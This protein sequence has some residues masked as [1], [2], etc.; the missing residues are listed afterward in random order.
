MW[1][2][3]LKKRKNASIQYVI[4]I[5]NSDYPVSLDR[6][7][8]Y[9]IMPDERAAEDNCLR[10]I[11]EIWGLSLCFRALC[12]RRFAR[13]IAGVHGP[14]RSRGCRYLGNAKAEGSVE[15]QGSARNESAE[16]PATSKRLIVI[17]HDRFIRIPPTFHLH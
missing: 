6:H 11:D 3:G 16:S 1:N 2:D 9:E 13:A 8:I 12:S 4:C 15:G 10:V 17:K 7:K 14:T 5:D